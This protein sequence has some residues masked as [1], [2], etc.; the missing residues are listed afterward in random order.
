MR[1][2]VILIPAAG[3]SRR[4]G[5]RDKLLEDAGGEPLLRRVASRAASVGVPVIVALPRGERARRAALAGLRVDIAE[6]DTPAEGMAASLRAGAALAGPGPLM[7]ALAD[8]PDLEAGDF[9]TLLAAFDDD[10]EAPLRAA[11]ETG[12]PGHPV[13]LPADLAARLPHLGG[14]EGARSLLGGTPVRAVPLAGTRALTDL[15]TPGDW[16]RWRASHPASSA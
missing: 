5:S 9:A 11:S 14:D 8:M 12:E 1:P 13:I 3:A 10:R 4:F 6:V 2:P 7:I 15:D 16:A